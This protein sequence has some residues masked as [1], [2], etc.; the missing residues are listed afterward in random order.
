MGIYKIYVFFQHNFII[1]IV[2]IFYLFMYLFC[3]LL[4]FLMELYISASSYMDPCNHEY[5]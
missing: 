3:I 2:I 4:L 5:F 1:I